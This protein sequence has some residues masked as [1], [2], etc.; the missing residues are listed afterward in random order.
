MLGERIRLARLARGWSMREL[1]RRVGVSPQAVSN[2]ERGGDVPSS[3]VLL[4][5]AQELDKPLEFFF[6]RGITIT[7][8]T[9]AF[10][11]HACFPRQSQRHLEAHLVGV[12]ERFALVEELVGGGHF[13]FPN[14]FPCRVS[15]LE[16]AEQCAMQLRKAWQLGDDVISNL[17]ALFE[18]HGICVSELPSDVTGFDGCSFWAPL[19]EPASIAIPIV[20]VHAS[21]PGDRQR[22]T[23]A[24]ELAHLLIEPEPSC[25]AEKVV[26]RFAAALLA[27]A[28]LVRDALGDRREHLSL[29]ELHL[30][31]HQFGI[32]M[33]AL[34]LR[35]KELRIL[36]ETRAR[37]MVKAFRARGWHRHEPGDPYPREKPQRL[38]RL[39]LRALEENVI[40][41]QRAEYLLGEPVSTFTRRLS[42]EHGGLEAGVLG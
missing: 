14:G 29:Y 41:E 40:S 12:L 20:A 30:L 31:K 39:V 27:P 35:A 28:P 5:I 10:R 19:R 1:A 26:H 6:S 38:S 11:R 16:G 18:E 21:I 23:L 33:M 25:G 2:Y 7:E 4:R 37:E 34:I 36:P 13:Q 32:S 24:H 15:N 3:S 22:F 17:T 42:E 8:I 9:P